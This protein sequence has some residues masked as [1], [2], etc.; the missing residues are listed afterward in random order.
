MERETSAR[1][2]MSEWHPIDENAKLYPG[3]KKALGLDAIP[4]DEAH[5][6][7]N[8]MRGQMGV[9]PNRKYS[10]KGGRRDPE[11]FG[12]SMELMHHGDIGRKPTKGEYEA[13]FQ[14]V[15][16]LK[17]AAKNET[18][19][20][21]TAA[22][23]MRGVNAVTQHILSAV[24]LIGSLGTIDTKHLYDLQEENIRTRF[25]DAEKKL[26]DAK[27]AGKKFEQGDTSIGKTTQELK[28]K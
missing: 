10:I 27:K 14:A 9:R 12:E 20:S 3:G 6:E 8:M 17:E 23:I 22:K 2:N 15:Q 16:Q 4:S 28:G 24:G 26:S 5:D 21:K 13:A 1:G 19:F 25:Q 7:A 11:T 18:E